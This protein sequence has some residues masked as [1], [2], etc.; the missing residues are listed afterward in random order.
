MT[1]FRYLIPALVAVYALP[2]IAQKSACELVTQSEAA[3]IIGSDVETR[4]FAATC[5]YKSKALT[6]SKTSTLSLHLRIATKDNAAITAA[7]A[8]VKKSGGTV[9]DEPSLGKGA[10][11]ALAPNSN[12]IVVFKGDKMLTIDYRDS[13]PAKIPSGPMDKLRVAAKTALGRL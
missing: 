1:S 13:T 2:A 4:P 9:K 12:R 5:L 7:K 8:R 3:A 6:V 11:S 10:Y